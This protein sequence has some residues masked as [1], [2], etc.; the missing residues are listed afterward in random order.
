VTYSPDMTTP[1]D[2]G[3]ETRLVPVR[4]RNIVVRQLIDT[5]LFLL[6]R[7][8]RLASRDETDP[9]R[10]MVAIARIF[11]ILESAVVQE[12]DRDY[13]MDLTVAGDLELKDLLGFI[14]AFADDEKPKVR[15]GRVASKRN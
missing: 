8:A 15:R 9:Q 5:Q 3:K 12:E 1:E 14:T 6:S 10:R 4:D 2:P 7:E 11:D 13:L